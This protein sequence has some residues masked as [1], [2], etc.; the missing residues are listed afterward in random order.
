MSDFNERLLG[1]V[2]NLKDSFGDTVIEVVFTYGSSAS[3]S[4]YGGGNLAANIAHL[5]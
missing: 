3:E 4:A 2:S 5:I 1:T